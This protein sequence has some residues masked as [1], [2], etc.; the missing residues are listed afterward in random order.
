MTTAGR[1]LSCTIAM[2]AL[3]ACE[4]PYLDPAD[5]DRTCAQDT[6]CALV[7]LTDICHCQEPPTAVNV[8]E[9]RRAEADRVDAAP[10]CPDEGCVP[11]PRPWGDAACIAG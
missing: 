1:L 2:L 10:G 3:S 11:V 7:L 8:R 6:D 9:V 5:Y 4:P